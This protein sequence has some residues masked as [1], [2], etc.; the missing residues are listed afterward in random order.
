MKAARYWLTGH[1]GGRLLDG[2]MT[3]VRMDVHNDAAW[4]QPTTAGQPVLFTLWHGRLLPLAYLHRG[5]GVVALI[6]QSADGEYLTRVMQHW[7]FRAVRGSSSRGGDVAFRELV[8][9][10]RS[11]RS[12]AITP[13]GPRGPRERLKP[14]VLQLAQLTGAPIVL[15]ACGADRAWWFESWDRFLIPKPFARLRVA[16]GDAVTIPRDADAA[17]LTRTLTQLETQLGT[18]MRQVDAHD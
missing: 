12:I 1:L 5:Q 9:L 11:G 15:V 3:T 8:R 16:Y 14:G 2:L 18:L 10:V 4:R 17:T 13:D 6:S 7:G